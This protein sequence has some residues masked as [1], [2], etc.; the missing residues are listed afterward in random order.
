MMLMKYHFLLYCV[1]LSLS[2]FFQF[3]SLLIRNENTSFLFGMDCCSDCL[4][5][6]LNAS[7]K[8]SICIWLWKK[9]CQ[10]HR[11]HHKAK[12]IFFYSTAN[13]RS[14]QSSKWK[15]E[16]VRICLLYFLLLLLWNWS[17]NFVL[18]EYSPVACW[19][20]KKPLIKINNNE[21]NINYTHQ[22]VIHLINIFTI[23]NLCS[24]PVTI[25]LVNE[26][27]IYQKKKKKR[28]T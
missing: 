7:L 23:C 16:M 8:D 17:R 21:Q 4:L 11:H 1:R 22:T 14:S 5:T 9:S 15:H 19:L 24:R 27:I 13:K 25:R 20:K 28:E 6:L 26:A 12:I 3:G 18:I 2:N 10:L